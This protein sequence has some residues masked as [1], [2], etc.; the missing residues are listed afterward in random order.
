V[1]K[2]YLLKTC[3]LTILSVLWE[4]PLYW[5]LAGKK[6]KNKTDPRQ[7]PVSNYLDQVPVVG[8]VEG[9]PSVDHGEQDD[10]HRP[11][12]G[13][14]RL[15][16]YPFQDFGRRVG[17]T[18]AESFAQGNLTVLDL[19]VASR[20]TKIG[21]FNFVVGVDQQVFAFDVSV[22]HASF[23][24]IIHSIHQLSEPFPCARFVDVRIPTDDLQQT[25]VL[26]V[27]HDDVDP[28]VKPINSRQAHRFFKPVGGFY[29]LKE[30]D[31]IRMF[32][33]FNDLDLPR[34][35]LLQVICRR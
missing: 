27:F 10:P 5:S 12:V 18:P 17:V 6:N 9:Q 23:V 1:L 4:T 13:V 3:T 24:A 15:V 19:H 26:S 8:V 31:Q 29:R 11:D 2:P 21:Q 30:P 25:P 20:K 22:D 14:L 7:I 34:E 32:Q 35:K 28:G 33:T 16:R